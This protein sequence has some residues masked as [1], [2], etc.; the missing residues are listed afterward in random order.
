MRHVYRRRRD[1][2][3][4][5]LTSRFDVVGVAAGL[6]VTALTDR[7][8]ELVE[9]AG[10]RSIALFGIGEHV[11]GEHHTSGLVIGYS[12]SPAHGF[13]A[14]LERLAWVVEDA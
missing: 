4:E 9:R 6:H 8:R 3:L 11:L 2:V 1:A 5:V 13:A 14:A 10:S 7:E 12:R